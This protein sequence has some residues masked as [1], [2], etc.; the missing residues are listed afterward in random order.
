VVVAV[1]GL[2]GAAACSGSSD[3][4]ASSTT[5]GPAPTATSVVPTSTTTSGASTTSA[6]TTS[7]TIPTGPT[8][9]AEPGQT[10]GEPCTQGSS[11]DC[12]DPFGEGEFV[13][14]LGGAD[15]MAGPLSG[16]M[17]ADLDGNGYAGYPDRG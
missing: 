11:P 7:T 3:D 4:D 8:S 17:C 5:T 16:P 13:Y 2:G 12:I 9:T 1:L 15:C 14:L 10:P 6:P